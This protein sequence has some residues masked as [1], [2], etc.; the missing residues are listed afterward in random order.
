MYVPY[1]SD[2]VCM[3]M[4]EDLNLWMEVYGSKIKNQELLVMFWLIKLKMNLKHSW[5]HDTITK[6]GN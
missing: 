4:T 6:N 3:G 2:T 1:K 5:S